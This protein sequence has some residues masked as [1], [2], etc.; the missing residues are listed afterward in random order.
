MAKLNSE[1]KDII[2]KIQV[3]GY[4]K[5]ISK[6]DAEMLKSV[7]PENG[8]QVD[9]VAAF[10]AKRLKVEAT[11]KLVSDELSDAHASR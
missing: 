9:I 5:A 8:A 2:K 1:K 11:M 3:L 4:P 7:L 6:G 10:A